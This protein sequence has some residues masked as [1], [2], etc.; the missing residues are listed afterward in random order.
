MARSGPITSY[1]LLRPGGWTALL[2]D[3]PLAEGPLQQVTVGDVLQYLEDHPTS[4]QTLAI[5]AL[6]Y[7]D[8]DLDGS[9]VGRIPLAAVVLG[10]KPL[11]AIALPGAG[12]G[13]SGRLAAWCGEIQAQGFSCPELRNGVTVDAATVASSLDAGGVDLARTRLGDVPLVTLDPTDTALADITARGTYLTGTPLG[14]VRLDALSSGARTALVDCSALGSACPGDYTLGSA[15]RENAEALR[16]TGTLADL[17]SGVPQDVTFGDLLFSLVDP[18]YYPWED[19]PLQGV[20]LSEARAAAQYNP[21]EDPITGGTWTLGFVADRG[22]TSDAIADVRVSI[23]FPA[24]TMLNSRVDAQL[25][26]STSGPAGVGEIDP[27]TTFSGGRVELAIGDVAPGTAVQIELTSV[28]R[29]NFGPGDLRVEVG[30]D[31]DTSGEPQVT[32]AGEV[33]SVSAP[34]FYNGT[35]T[36]YDGGASPYQGAVGE[37]SEHPSNAPTISPDI[38][39]FGHL[40]YVGGYQQPKPTDPIDNDYYRIPAQPAGSRIVVSVDPMAA[41]VDLGLFRLTSAGGSVS[42]APPDTVGLDGV[43]VEDGTPS[44]EDQQ[45]A[46]LEVADAPDGYRTVDTSTV[47]GTAREQVSTQADGSYLIKVS[48]PVDRTYRPY[49]LR[50]TVITPKPEVHCPAVTDP[51]YAAPGTLATPAADLPAGTDAL[52]LVDRTRL[53][54][55]YP[56]AG[57]ATMDHLADFAAHAP[58]VSG[59]VIELDRYAGYVTA[60]NEADQNPCSVAAVNAVVQQIGAIV[61]AK[62]G[63]VGSPARDTV[64]SIT[65][66]GSDDLLPFAR[67]PDTVQR[68]NESTFEGD[69]RRA[70][71]PGGGAC[72]TVAAGDVDPCATPLSAAAFGS[73]L[74][75]DDPYGDL[76]PIPWLDRFLYVPDIAVGRLVETPAQIDAALAQYRDPAVG[77]QLDLDTALTAGYGAWADAGAGLDAVLDQRGMDATH[78]SPD[79]WS[80]AQL[81][82]ALFPSGGATPDVAAIHAHMDPSRLLTGSDEIVTTDDY[83]VDR[84]AGRLLFTLGCHAGLNLPNR[85]FGGATDDWTESLAGKA[86]YVGNTGYGYADDNVQGLT[87]RLLAL[88]ANRVGGHQSAG[89][90]LM[91]AKQAYL[92]ELGLYSNYDEKV[93]MQA[94]FYGLPMYRFADPVADT[95]DPPAPTTH[96]D[97]ATGLVA[98]S[99]DFDPTFQRHTVGDRT[100][101]T[102]A[103]EEP[104]VVA[105]RP[106]LPRTSVPVTVA[107]QRAH[108]ALVT[109]LT[110]DVDDVDPAVAAPVVGEDAAASGPD[111]SGSFPST[112]TNVNRYRTPDGVRQDLVLLPARVDMTTDP[113]TGDVTATEERFTHAGVEVFYGGGD[114]DRKPEIEEPT[115]ARN[116]STAT[117]S[118]PVTDASGVKRVVVLT[119][120][121]AGGTWQVLDSADGDLTRSGTTWT[122]SA[123]V[124]AGGTLRW[125]AQAVDGAG[126][127]ALSGN[128]GALNRVSAVRPS[129]DAGADADL[130]LGDRLT[131]EV[132]ISDADS[133]SWTATLDTGLGPEPV[134][135]RD[136][137]VLVDVAPST[138]GSNTAT[139][140]VC[141]DGDRCASDTFALTVRQN[142][143]PYAG[144]SLDRATATTGAT[145][146]ATSE[147]SDPDGDATQVRHVWRVNGG[148]VLDT[149]W[150]SSGTSTLDLG[151]AGNGDVGD[152]ITVE[153]TARDAGQTGA[154]TEARATVVSTAPQLTMPAAA[155][156]R[157]GDLYAASA[158]ASDVDGAGLT[159]VVDY[160]DGTA[161]AAVAV[162]N[163]SLALAHTY[164]SE[165][166]HVVHVTVTDPQGEQASGSTTV[167]VTPAHDPVAP[168]EVR[169]F[170]TVPGNA[171]VALTWQPPAVGADDLQHYLVRASDG[172]TF[173]TTATAFTVTG[174]TNGA[175]YFF[176]VSAVTAAGTATVRSQVVVPNRPPTPLVPSA[177]GF[178][179]ASGP[180]GT[181]VVLTGKN[182]WLA[183][184]RFHG[185]TTPAEVVAR[186]ATQVTVRVPAGATTGILTVTSPGGTGTST[187]AF[188]VSAT[189]PPVVSSVPLSAVVGATISVSGQNLL[190]AKVRFNNATLPGQVVSRTATAVKVVVPAGALTGTLSV[191]TPGGSAVSKSLRIDPTGAPAVTSAPASALRGATVTIGGKNLLAARVYVNGG[192]LEATVLTRTATSLQVVVP[193]GAATG[194]VRVVTPFGTAESPKVVAITASPAPK[195]TGVRT[196]AGT[197]NGPAGVPVTIQGSGLLGATVWFNGR[198][199]PVVKGTASSLTIAVPADAVT[200]YVTV[201]TSGGTARSPL[202]FAVTG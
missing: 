102:V 43:P 136:G 54:D 66:V 141:D 202:V 79:D 17:A 168:S 18:S 137:K 44:E 156:V 81:L 198:P 34:P 133:T 12:G 55:A 122:G 8:F 115:V 121:T 2:A 106:L 181:Q 145:L 73:Y 172:R 189:P 25:R 3:T 117:F 120:T 76:D 92:G 149:G 171:Q 200:G 173:T 15:Q 113:V 61:R 167:E 41:D 1:A 183:A 39:Y 147:V 45:S 4:P 119:Q 75:T 110:T 180:I 190:A 42:G 148:V 166:D 162:V 33:S 104:Q 78:L 123:D 38:M 86:V 134:P 107:G 174:L 35:E 192:A 71:A 30:G 182:L 142:V 57:P 114:D 62:L 94:T 47:P 100:Y 185:V 101:S 126:N 139:L 96:S 97:P 68:S 49:N 59:Q 23:V 11:S 31:P 144:V 186:T 91:Y 112:F 129:I 98:A 177:T 10:A 65:V 116:G 138:V 155:T 130:E 64:A 153:A 24:S 187:K 188:T 19:L 16:A 90:A 108:D 170:D 151:V 99:F 140:T 72:P 143:P 154:T 9:V 163:G 20:N 60:R 51:G 195:I 26:V 6:T 118:V 103:G 111:G 67:V 46:P 77:G 74:L 160:G 5:R 159:A 28:G 164:T 37:G 199:A 58:G 82:D 132:T 161:P 135:V 158:Q 27:A 157:S 175:T 146:T 95:A 63:P 14:D 89:Q 178:S 150:Q 29:L 87:E 165:G 13:A 127:V 85:Y 32:A 36:V 109:E 191:L 196:S 131:R 176:D 124:G 152:E 125:F 80:K 53:V 22:D 184:V 69:L 93:L 197:T 40:G 48:G 179:P 84:L 7:A 194:K 56:A 128:R 201:W 70:N 50:Y 83:D 52:F 21:S 193:V 169:G 105:D 88:Y